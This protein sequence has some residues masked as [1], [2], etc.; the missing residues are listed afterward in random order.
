MKVKFLLDGGATVTLDLV[1]LSEVT[2]ALPEDGSP[3]WIWDRFG[4]GVNLAKVAG[5]TAVEDAPEPDGQ[6][7]AA[8]GISERG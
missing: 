6:E 5:F 3:A 2:G 4:A 1:H 8:Y 7:S